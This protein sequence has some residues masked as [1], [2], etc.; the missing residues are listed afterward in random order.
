[1]T[2]IRKLTE[3]YVAAFD[4]RDLDRIAGYFSD[5]F[6]LT[7]PDVIA[8]TPKAN[9]LTY[10]KELFDSHDTLNFKSRSILVDGDSSVIH[11]TLKLDTMTLDGVDVIS[12][13]SGKMICMEAYLTKRK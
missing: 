11:F 13:K 3:E 5:G 10:L 4:A 1:M 9:V 8:L 12:W 6:K 2:D 7:D